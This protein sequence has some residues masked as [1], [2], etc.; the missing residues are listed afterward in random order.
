[1]QVQGIYLVEFG[2]VNEIDSDWFIDLDLYRIVGVIVGYA[3]YGVEFVLAVEID[4]KAVHQ[5]YHLLGRLARYLR[6]YYQSAVESFA[7][8]LG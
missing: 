4:V 3:I 2:H 8:V 7:Y 1:M 5:H 6:V